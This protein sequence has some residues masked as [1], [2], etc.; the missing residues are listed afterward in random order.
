MVRCLLMFV[1]K[2]GLCYIVAELQP[3]FT[4]FLGGKKGKEKKR[5]M[6]DWKR[7]EDKGNSLGP[8]MKS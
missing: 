4:P 8:L 6:R 2:T 1:I 5:E 3:Q 7:K